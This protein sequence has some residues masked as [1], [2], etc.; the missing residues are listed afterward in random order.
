M[1][2]FASFFVSAIIYRR[3]PEIHKR[4]ILLATV[5]LLFA[6]A[7]RMSFLTPPAA[8]AVWLSPVFIGITYDAVTRRRVHP[9]YLIGLPVLLLGASRLFFVESEGW[10]RIG[11]VL[12]RHLM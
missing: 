7:G 6:A 12:I 8:A 2:L 11:R 10:L 9:A 1:A 3:R 5:A 4:L